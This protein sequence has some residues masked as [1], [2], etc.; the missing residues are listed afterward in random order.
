MTGAIREGLAADFLLVD[1][2][3]PEF[4]PSHDLMWELV[5]YGNRDQIDAVFTAGM[6]RLW[7]GWPVQWDAR[8]LLA[9]VREV[10]ADAIARAPIQRVHKPSAE[11][12]ALGH[13]A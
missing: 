4:T 12:R 9:E 1:L 2:D 5:R 10:T 3:R 7:Q 11:H 8:A 13:F 6:L